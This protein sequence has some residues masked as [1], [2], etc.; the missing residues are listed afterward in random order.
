MDFEDEKVECLSLELLS[1]SQQRNKHWLYII[2]SSKHFTFLAVPSR[3]PT[4]VSV[5]NHGLNELL[6]RWD[7]LTTQYANGRILGYNVYYKRTQ[8][9]Y[10]SDTIV[11]IN[12]TKLPKA[13]LPNIQTGERYQ[14][15]VAAFT[16]VGT[17][18]RSSLVYVTKGKKNTKTNALWLSCRYQISTELIT[19]SCCYS[20]YFLFLFIIIVIFFLYKVV[21]ALWTSRLVGWISPSPTTILWTAVFR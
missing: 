12:D 6:V 4:K 9:Y 19:N 11:R 3:A 10:Y 15:S 1:F 14:I 21:K 5:V 7:P 18:P 13:V 8:Y 20:F 16:S 2:L 17:G